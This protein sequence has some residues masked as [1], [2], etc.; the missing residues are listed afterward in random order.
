MG[1]QMTIEVSPL[2]RSQIKRRSKDGQIFDIIDY[3]FEVSNG[4][5]RC[6]VNVGIT[7]MFH[8]PAE[9]LGSTRL[10]QDEL[11]QAASDWLRFVIKKGEYDPFK[12]P[13]ADITVA[14]PSEIMDYWAEHREIPG[15][16]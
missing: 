4:Q 7:G 8:D 13:H 2:D 12:H 3:P 16:L 11:V 10:S 15:W 9:T 14:I 1:V 5:E 6:I